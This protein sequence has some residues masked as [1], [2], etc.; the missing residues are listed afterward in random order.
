M[1]LSGSFS[2]FMMLT[3]RERVLPLPLQSHSARENRCRLR[4]IVVMSK[5]QVAGCIPVKR[6]LVLVLTIAIGTV[7]V[8]LTVVNS[9]NGGT[10]RRRR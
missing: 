1:L 10:R 6:V 4:T 8:L 9:M 5:T 7:M 2:G 3:V